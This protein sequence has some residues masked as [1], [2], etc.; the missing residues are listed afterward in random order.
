MP[1][2]QR[3]SSKIIPNNLHLGVLYSGWKK[4]KRKIPTSKTPW[5][6][7]KNKNTLPTEEHR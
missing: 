1:E 6:V 7:L 2:T 5:K 4:K 3:T